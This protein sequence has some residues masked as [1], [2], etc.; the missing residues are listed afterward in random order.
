MRP[1][2]RQTSPKPQTVR[3]RPDRTRRDETHPVSWRHPSTVGDHLLR[4]LLDLWS[5]FHHIVLAQSCQQSF[6]QT[7][8]VP[9]RRHPTSTYQS[10]VLPR[11][12]VLDVAER[13]LEVL[14]LDADLLLGLFGV[15][16]GLDLER[17]DGAHLAL[18]VV[19]LG[20]ERLEVVL[21]LVDDTLLLEQRPVLLEVD[22]LRLLRQQL[23]ASARVVVALLERLQGRGRLPPEPQGAADL[24]PVDLQ[25]RASL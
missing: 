9:R 1:I 25:G 5:G 15:L 22:L 4:L 2:D 8:V 3:A 18:D 11:S 6:P 7:P 24:G 17:L 19:R 20:L 13:L 21:N 23:Q 16:D 10:E 14:E 12:R